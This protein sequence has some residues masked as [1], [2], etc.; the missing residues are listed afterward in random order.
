MGSTIKYADQ[1]VQANLWDYLSD[2]IS[3]KVAGLLALP[4]NHNGEQE[5]R[6]LFGEKLVSCNTLCYKKHN[7]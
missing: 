5:T 1:Y 6:E 3:H 7:K 2:R 4:D